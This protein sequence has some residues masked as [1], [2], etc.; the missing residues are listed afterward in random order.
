M[1]LLFYR[2][3]YKNSEIEIIFCEPYEYIE[4]VVVPVFTPVTLDIE[5]S[6]HLED[7]PALQRNLDLGSKSPLSL[8]S[9]DGKLLE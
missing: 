1:F 5:I 9:I 3:S 8:F 7:T 2:T 4:G 6:G